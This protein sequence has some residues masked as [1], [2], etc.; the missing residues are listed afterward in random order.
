MADFNYSRCKAEEINGATLVA[1]ARSMPMMASRRLIVIDDAEK[2]KAADMAPLEAYIENPVPETCLVLIGSK[3]DLRKG[4]FAKANKKKFVHSADPLKE[5][6]ISPFIRERAAARRIR[7][8]SG[9]DSA[10]SAAIGPDASALDDALER[11]GLFAGGEAVAP[12][13][14]AEVVSSVRQ[15]KVFDLTDALGNKDPARALA[16]L[17]E[18]LRNREEPLRLLALVARHMRQLIL[19]RVHAG[20]NLPP[21]EM[22]GILGVP[23]FAVSRLLAQSRRFSSGLQ[24]ENALM[25]I[26]RADMELKSSRRPSGLILEDAIMDLCLDN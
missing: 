17:E 19:A 18:F 22:A 4:L 11:L 9:T 2:L 12:E 16:L 7:L 10:L 8:Q 25:R 26:A 21:A 13:H 20:Q 15:N 3:F 6:Q 24:L 14:V 1:Q 5:N 23:P